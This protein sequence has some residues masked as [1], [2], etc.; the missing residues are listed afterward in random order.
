MKFDLGGKKYV[1][2]A[3]YCLERIFQWQIRL[4]VLFTSRKV[5]IIS[6]TSFLSSSGQQ[7][8]NSI[9]DQVDLT[10]ICPR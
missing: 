1:V 5:L 7:K 6:L 4:A 2:V 8:T 9:T 10:S 3:Y